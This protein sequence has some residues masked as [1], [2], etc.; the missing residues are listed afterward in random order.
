MHLARLLSGIAWFHTALAKSLVAYVGDD[1]VEPLRN[2]VKTSWTCLSPSQKPSADE[3]ASVDF[4]VPGSIA[5]GSAEPALSKLS[6]CKVY[7][8]AYTGYD[9]VNLSSIPASWTIA[10]VHQGGTPIAE[11]VLRN[12]LEWSIGQNAM[13]SV[14]RSCTWRS[15]SP[16]NA[17]PM[18]KMLVRHKELK[19]QTL[20]I[21]GY[22][23]I[24]AAIATRAAAFGLNVIAVDAHAQNPA[25]A[26]LSWLGDDSDLPKLMEKSDFVVVAVPLLPSTRGM[27]NADNIKLMSNTSVLIN[28][29]RGPVVEEKALYDALKSKQIAGAVLDVWWHGWEWLHPGEVGPSGW[30][31]DYDFSQLDNVIMTPHMSAMTTQAKEDA[32][33]QIAA[34]MDHYFRAEPLDN[35]VR[36]ATGFDAIV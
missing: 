29:A 11:Y 10:D 26:P 3:L 35:V 25:P 18:S 16:G 34:N 13:E 33:V 30:P 19:G 9:D 23:H 21:V 31:A 15:S 36:N 22:G 5:G 4:Y 2:T 20:G 6:N 14:F 17:C 7:Q 24:G 32:V 28:I 1:N 27:V 8:L 12:M